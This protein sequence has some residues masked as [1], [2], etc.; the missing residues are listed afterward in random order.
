MSQEGR[1][2]DLATGERP[3][4]LQLRKIARFLMPAM[5]HFALFITNP[6]GTESV[7]ELG[8]DHKTKISFH[9]SS[10]AVP[11]QDGFSWYRFREKIGVTSLDDEEIEAAGELELLIRVSPYHG[12]A[13][14]TG[15]LLGN[16]LFDYLQKSRKYS[17]FVENCQNHAALLWCMIADRKSAAT[18]EL[19]QLYWPSQREG[20]RPPDDPR[21]NGAGMLVTHLFYHWKILQ[22]HLQ[23]VQRRLDPAVRLNAC[24]ILRPSE[25]KVKAM[26]KEMTRLR[27]IIVVAR[28]APVPLTWHDYT[29]G[30]GKNERFTWRPGYLEGIRK[31]SRRYEWRWFYDEASVGISDASKLSEY[32]PAD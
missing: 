26:E 31:H 24:V 15:K 2:A 3:I 12:G 22:Y 19:R 11:G 10:R 6:D 16:A 29:A 28:H 13:H 27:M 7:H 32:I 23:N 14:V 18:E 25:T 17:L 5:G 20:A 21:C 30:I 8:L 4:F 9:K 1:T